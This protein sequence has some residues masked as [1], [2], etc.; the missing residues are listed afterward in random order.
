MV[1]MVEGLPVVV[2]CLGVGG[3]VRSC[4]IDQSS[5][6]GGRQVRNLVIRPSLVALSGARAQ[7]TNAGHR[8]VQFDDPIL[9]AGWHTP[10][11]P[12]ATPDRQAENRRRRPPRQN[13]CDSRVSQ[14][15]TAP[16]PLTIRPRDRSPSSAVRCTVPHSGAPRR[17]SPLP[18]AAPPPSPC[19]MHG[20]LAER[21]Q[22]SC[23]FPQAAPRGRL[24]I[25]RFG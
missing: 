6:M 8:L 19:P 23:R 18:P 20:V 9:A 22:E 11:S 15:P 2:G 25:G 4:A 5:T 21:R 13:P 14:H 12:Q 17:A 16:D 10:A 1:L 7:M 3:A 24:V